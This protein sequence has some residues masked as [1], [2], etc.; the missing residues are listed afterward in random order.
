[1][2]YKC[3]ILAGGFGTRLGELGKKIPKALLPIKNKP[4]LE[5]IIS[6]IEEIPD[7]NEIYI[8]SNEKF[9]NQFK[10]WLQKYNGSK[11]IKLKS[12]GIKT[13]EESNGPIK[14]RWKDIEEL[15]LDKEDILLMS[16][17]NLIIPKLNKISEEFSKGSSSIVAVCDYKDKEVSRKL[18]VPV[19]NKTGKITEIKE[20]P[21]NPKNTLGCPL[22]YFM[23]KKDMIYFKE[24]REVKNAN[25]GHILEL[26]VKNSKLYGHIFKEKIIDIG[27]IKNYEEAKKL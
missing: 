7:I 18:V 1:M 24:L 16:S 17:D 21:K 5:Y 6:K 20:K 9:Y 19:I 8:L 12:D 25:F 22:I 23:K 27:V 4:L 10:K 11:V 15:G 13:P 2:T 14:D 26:V 3:I